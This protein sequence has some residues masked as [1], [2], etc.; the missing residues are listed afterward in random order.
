MA[1][2]KALPSSGKLQKVDPRQ[3]VPTRVIAVEMG[4]TRQTVRRWL[5]AAGIPYMSKGPR[6]YYARADLDAFIARH[7]VTP[8]KG[9]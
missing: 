7:K 6:R 5:D 3:H 9:A 8:S 1:Q 4:M 2:R